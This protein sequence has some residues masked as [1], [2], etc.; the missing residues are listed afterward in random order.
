LPFKDAKQEFTGMPQ[1]AIR[2]GF[3]MITDE[4]GKKVLEKLKNPEPRITRVRQIG[5]EP[6][7]WD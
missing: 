5:N 3:S 6:K 2:K 4:V 7:T 1:F